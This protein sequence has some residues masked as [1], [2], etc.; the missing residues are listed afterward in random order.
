M[1]TGAPA[2]W[3]GDRMDDLFR[4][5]G[6]VRRDPRVEAWFALTDPLRLIARE[7]FERMRACGPDVR[8]LLHDGCPMAC[9]EDA[10]FAY[11]NAF[12][13]H[14]SVGFFHGAT[15]ADPAHVLEGEGRCM[16]HVKLRPGKALNE[17][18]LRD[19]IDAAYRDIGQ[20][21]HEGR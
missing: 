18:A 14:A 16:R 9:V 1:L 6:A 20:R 10:P 4:L 5:S 12:K 21:L 3:Q 11:V 13:A 2:L 19:L 8:E 15:L 17:A 7:W